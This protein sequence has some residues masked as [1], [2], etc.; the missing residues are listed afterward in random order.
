MFL[1]DLAVRCAAANVEL[2]WRS[3]KL[4]VNTSWNKRNVVQRYL[5]KYREYSANNSNFSTVSHS[6]ILK[7]ISEQY[8]IESI[9]TTTEYIPHA[10]FI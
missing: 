1:G 8:T 6:L 10:L 4:F 2:Q 5:V 3:G 9:I 7:L